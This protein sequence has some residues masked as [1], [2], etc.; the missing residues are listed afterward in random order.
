MVWLAGFINHCNL[1]ELRTVLTIEPLIVYVKY[2][3]QQGYPFLRGRRRGSLLTGE[4]RLPQLRE[5]IQH[6]RKITLVF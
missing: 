5:S 6:H 3:I 4:A 2:Y 1:G